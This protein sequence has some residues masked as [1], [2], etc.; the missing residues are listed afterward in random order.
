LLLPLRGVFFWV[1]FASGCLCEVPL[2]EA[3][4]L[5]GVSVFLSLSEGLLG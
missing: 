4:S 3:F 5:G 2:V 1:F